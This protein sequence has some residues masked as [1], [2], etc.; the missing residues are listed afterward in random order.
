[1]VRPIVTVSTSARHPPARAAGGTKRCPYPS[2]DLAPF[3]GAYLAAVGFPV[4]QGPETV[5][6]LPL[7]ICAST[8]DVDPMVSMSEAEAMIE[9]DSGNPDDTVT[10]SRRGG[11]RRTY[12]EP[13]CHDYSTIR[14]IT[15]REAHRR[16]W[17]PCSKCVLSD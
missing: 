7:H 16:Y 6:R 10:V 8:D 5:V 17:V 2:A 9:Q 1:M 12:H 13:G 4:F 3:L 11:N 14:E 15:R